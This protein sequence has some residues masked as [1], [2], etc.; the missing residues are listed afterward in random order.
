LIICV[1]LVVEALARNNRALS[2][3]GGTIGVVGMLLKQTVPVLYRKYRISV[4]LPRLAKEPLQWR[5][6][7][8][9]TCPP[10]HYEH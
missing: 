3:G 4:L 1:E 9:W 2:D 10:G 6:P 5:L 8:P 7:G